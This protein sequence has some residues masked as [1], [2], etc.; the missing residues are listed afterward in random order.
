MSGKVSAFRAYHR[1]LSAY[2]CFERFP[3]VLFCGK[4]ELKVLLPTK[5]MSNNICLVQFQEKKHIILIQNI[6]PFI[7]YKL[8]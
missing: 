1:A 8:F 4:T 2:P 7:S 6:R 3:R 5:S